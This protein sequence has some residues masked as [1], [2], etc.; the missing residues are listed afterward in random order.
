MDDDGVFSRHFR[1]ITP[2]SDACEERAVQFFKQQLKLMSD[3]AAA[4]VCDNTT[5]SLLVCVIY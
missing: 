2:S 1:Q 4:S 5:S 3:V